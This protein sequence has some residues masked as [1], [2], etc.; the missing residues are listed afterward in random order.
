MGWSEDSLDAAEEIAAVFESL[1]V[2]Y[3]LGGSM[4][5]SVWSEPRFTR[6][7]DM[8]AEL[9]ARD[10]APLIAALSDRWYADEHL[11]R[12]AVA[13]HSSFHLIRFRRMVKVDV[14]VPPSTGHHAA[15]WGRARIVKLSREATRPVA[16]TSAEDMLI[17]KLV[18]FREGGEVSELQWR[19]VTGLIRT[20]GG[21]L[22]WAYIRSWCEQLA[23][24]ELLESA[25]RQVGS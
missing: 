7:V 14:F 8:I 15:K 24:D 18:W 6:D 13:A 4:A 19:D 3:L 9:A 5:V 20:L 11:I 21:E 25:R 23:L 1:G 10:V 2:R 22:D 12:G 17:Q 16:T